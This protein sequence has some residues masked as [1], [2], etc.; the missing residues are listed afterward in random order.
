[1]SRK[2]ERNQIQDSI[3]GETTMT[4]RP[5]SPSHGRQEW[6]EAKNKRWTTCPPLLLSMRGDE[7][8]KS[9]SPFPTGGHMSKQAS[10]Q[11]SRQGSRGAGELR[12]RAMY[13]L[14]SRFC[15]PLAP[16]PVRGNT[17][18]LSHRWL[19]PQQQPPA[20]SSPPSP[21]TRSG[22]SHS[23]A[24]QSKVGTMMTS[25]SQRKVTVT[26]APS[27][28][29]QR[30]PFHTAPSSLRGRCSKRHGIPGRSAQPVPP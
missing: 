19:P 3:K 20:S 14:H 27:P 16:R 1:M 15:F 26:R 18:R 23:T 17:C 10:K 6:S 11:A 25:T 30:L 12:F 5:L 8:S 4:G 9:V 13:E 28:S 22:V 24:M 21:S 2:H 7:S 29:T